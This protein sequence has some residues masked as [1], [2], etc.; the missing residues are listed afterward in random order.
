MKQTITQS[1]FI[2]AFLHLNR[3]G[4]FTYKGK[5]ALYK[6]LTNLENETGEELELDVI[7]ICIDF[8]EYEDLEDY[9]K[10]NNA[11]FTSIKE[12]QNS[13]NVIM[14]DNEAFIVENF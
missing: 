4:D 13:C 5:V 6:Y 11:E 9:N 7:A 8:S 3:Q 12:L 14:I 1:S 2:D 10:S